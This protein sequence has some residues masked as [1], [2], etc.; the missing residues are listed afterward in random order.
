MRPAL[1]S[2][3]MAQTADDDSVADL[4]DCRHRLRLR[5]LRAADAAA[6]H[7]AGDRRAERADH[8]RAGARRDAA[9]RGHGA[10]GAG[11]RR[12]VEWARTLFFV[13]AHRRRRVRPARR[14]SHRSPRT[15]PGADLQHPALRVCGV[16]GRV[17]DHA[18]AAAVLPLPGL[19]RRLRGVRRGGGLAGRAVSRPRAAREGARLHAG[20]LVVRRVAGRQRQ[21]P[22]R[23]S[24]PP[25][26]RPSTAATRPGATR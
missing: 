18:A 13:P 20:V 9:A 12:Y 7:Q 21:R 23:H 6:H 14:L 15:P 17:R 19:H 2:P 25:A 5:H 22:G 4:R 10:V 3:H 16:R 24:G 1:Q 11:R 26:C 8:R